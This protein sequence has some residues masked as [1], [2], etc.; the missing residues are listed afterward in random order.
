MIQT[1]DKAQEFFAKAALVDFE[2]LAEAQKKSDLIRAESC[3]QSAFATDVRPAIQEW[4]KSN[5]LPRDPMQAF[6]E[7]GYLERISRQR[8][9]RNMTA[10]SSYA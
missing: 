10:V 5:G 2:R 4:R 6:L 9:A 7:S 8:G 3:L 1:V